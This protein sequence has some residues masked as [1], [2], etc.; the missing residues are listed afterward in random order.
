MGQHRALRPAG[1]AAGVEQPGEIVRRRALDGDRDRIVLEQR[2]VSRAADD[3]QPLERRRRVRGE[4]A[5]ELGRGE[6][7]AAR[8][9]AR[10]CSRARRPCSLAFAGTA[11][12]P[13]HQRP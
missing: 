2:G 10:A 5:L 1:G 7:D 11:A 12:R 13:A 3:D 6:A 4:I 8:R 9:S